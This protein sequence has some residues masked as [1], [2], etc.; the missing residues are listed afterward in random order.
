MP[1]EETPT[2]SPSVSGHELEFHEHARDQ[3]IQQI[4]TY[5]EELVREAVS[6]AKRQG[7]PLVLQ[8]DVQSAAHRMQTELQN[9]KDVLFQ[10][11]G[12]GLLGVFLQGFTAE[13]L[14][15]TPNVWAAVVYVLVGFAGLFGIFWSLIR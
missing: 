14:T 12:A 3:A 15:P 13:M 6:T 11:M 9:R 5:G 2:S 7:H 4:R 8:K 10:F 1:T